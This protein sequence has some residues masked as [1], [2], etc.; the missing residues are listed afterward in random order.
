MAVIAKGV[1]LC[2]IRQVFTKKT[3][4]F[5]SA[6]ML[7]HIINDMSIDAGLIKI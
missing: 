7:Y 2:Q 6:Q 5:S 3:E 4:L 1:N